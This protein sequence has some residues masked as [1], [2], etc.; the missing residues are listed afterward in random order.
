MHGHGVIIPPSPSP[1]RSQDS[2]ADLHSNVGRYPLNKDAMLFDSFFSKCLSFCC[3]S[4]APDVLIS[5]MHHLVDS[6]DFTK[7]GHAMTH[8][9]RS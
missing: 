6:D 2:G 8:S 1:I 3:L 5:F 7:V 9:F 4:M